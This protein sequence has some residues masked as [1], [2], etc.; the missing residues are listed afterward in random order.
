MEI[1]FFRGEENSLQVGFCF[2]GS[3]LGKGFG[4][5]SFFYFFCAAY[6]VTRIL[7]SLMLHGPFWGGFI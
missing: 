7:C 4:P 2:V 1:V 3:T 5:R 6:T